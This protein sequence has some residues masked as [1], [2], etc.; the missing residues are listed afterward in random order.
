MPKVTHATV[1]VNS[2]QISVMYYS[3]F[4]MVNVYSAREAALIPLKCFL[5]VLWECHGARVASPAHVPPV[6]NA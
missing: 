3:V 6:S 1:A 2:N 4:M 5:D